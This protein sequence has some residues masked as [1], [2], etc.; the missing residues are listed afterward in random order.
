MVDLL[1]NPVNPAAARQTRAEAE[2]L[3]FR[4]IGQTNVD[5]W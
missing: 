4:K 3:P 2:S 5:G 1:K